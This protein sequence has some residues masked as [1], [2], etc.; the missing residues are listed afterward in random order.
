MIRRIDIGTLVDFVADA[1][2]ELHVRTNI[3]AILKIQAGPG[4][5]SRYHRIPKSLDVETRQPQGQRLNRID[6]RRR[7]RESASRG[8]LQA[9]AQ[10]PHRADRRNETRRP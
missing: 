9:W 5:E 4:H 7:L 3:P 6:S 10:D 2:L 8:R 1:H